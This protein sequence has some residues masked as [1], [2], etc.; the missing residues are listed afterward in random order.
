MKNKRKEVLS[1]D[2]LRARVVLRKLLTSITFTYNWVKQRPEYF[3]ELYIGEITSDFYDELMHWAYKMYH[4]HCTQIHGKPGSL[5]WS[6]NYRL[7]FTKDGGK[8]PIIVIAKVD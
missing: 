3:S 8:S 6:L 2:E 5:E 7:I 4:I 1:A